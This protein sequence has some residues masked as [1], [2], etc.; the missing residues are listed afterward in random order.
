MLGRNIQTG[1][2]IISQII[3][4]ASGQFLF[5]IGMFLAGHMGAARKVMGTAIDMDSSMA[6]G[7][8]RIR[9]FGGG[10]AIIGGVLFIYVALK[11][12]LRKSKLET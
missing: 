7:A 10:L 1:K 9:D 5:I 4:Y 11:A 6:I 12:L 3:L 8:A 2:L